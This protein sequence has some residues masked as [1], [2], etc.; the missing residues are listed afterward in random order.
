MTAFPS[1]AFAAAS[2]AEARHSGILIFGCGSFA[3]DLHRAAEAEGISV[4]GFVVSGGSAST[5][6][7]LP[8][9]ALTALP[10][11][12]TAAQLKVFPS[13]TSRASSG[14]GCQNSASSCGLRAK[15]FMSSTT[16]NSPCVSA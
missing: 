8:V 14:A 9:A 15:R 1:L 12:W 13:A 10:A 5:C 7:G 2:P 4:R 16:L 11:G 3:R 6:A